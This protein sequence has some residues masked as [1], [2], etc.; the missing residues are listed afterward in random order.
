[1]KHLFTCTI[2]LFFTSLYGQE[3]F[4]PV[5]WTPLEKA[6]VVACLVKGTVGN[7]VTEVGREFQFDFTV[8]DVKDITI[9]GQ[10][11][12]MYQYLY[13]YVGEKEMDKHTVVLIHKGPGG[14]L[15]KSYPD[16][17]YNRT[18][19]ADTIHAAHCF[20]NLFP[21]MSYLIH[22]PQFVVVQLKR[23]TDISP[24]QMDIA[25]VNLIGW[26]YKAQFGTTD[27]QGVAVKYE[28]GK[29]KKVQTVQMEFEWGYQYDWIT[30]YIK[31]TI[32]VQLMPPEAY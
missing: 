23:I 25:Y 13:Y 27:R 21:F 9:E 24:S 26:A 15:V 28:E 8:R 20:L 14:N 16:F 17:I 2:L 10:L 19:F 22:T 12:H 5:L 31:R 6:R 7:Y 29:G 30:N 11:T 4:K 32:N 1:M 18:K 3:Y